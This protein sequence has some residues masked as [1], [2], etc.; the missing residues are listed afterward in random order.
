MTE[1]AIIVKRTGLSRKK[2]SEMTEEELIIN[3]KL[4]ETELDNRKT[5]EMVG[6]GELFR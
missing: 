1:I 3:R 4:I 5:E 6:L 2:L